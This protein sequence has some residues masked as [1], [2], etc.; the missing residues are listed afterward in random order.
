[1]EEIVAD[2]IIVGGGTAGCVISARLAEYGFETLLLS[3][4]SN[5]TLNSMMREKSLFNQLF[6]NPQFKHYLPASSSAN[7]NDRIL[8]IIVWN[9]LGGNSI[10][11]GGI[12][13]LMANDW[14]YFINAT[15][16]QS[17]HIKTMSKFYKMVENFTSTK[18]FSS[19]N[20]YGN[21]G[22]LKITQVYD[23]IFN[24]I[25]KK[26][27]KEL[28]ETFTDTSA[29]TL[30]YGFSFEASSFTNGIRSWSC[31][32]YLTSTLNKYPNLK[33]LT[34]ATAIKFNMNE[35]TKQ[36]KNVL[37]ISKDGL[38][39]GI[40]RKEYILSAG[41]IFSPHLLMLSGIGDRNILRENNILV[42]HELKQVGKNL[43]ENGMIIIKYQTQNFSI[44]QSI[45][46]ALINTQLR[47]NHS[48][49]DTFIILK[50]D[51]NTMHLY[52][53]IFNASPKSTVG[54]ISLYNSNPLIPPKIILD[55]LTD[56]KDIQTFINAINYVRKIMS[57]NTIKHYAN[58]TEILPGL[59][60][61]DLTAYIK[62]T[63]VP[64][65][66]FIGTCSIGQNAE[67]SVV[68]NLFKVH[69]ISNLRI[70]DASIFPR[71][72]STKTGPFL[73]VHALAEKAADILQKIYS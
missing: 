6:L 53:F 69:G 22:F 65:Y 2:F 67:N 57:T 1:M 71:K 40:A 52:V 56:S 18:P 8:D 66:H 41:T 16:D 50:Q 19:L 43:I 42:K 13:R 54:F 24:K 3:S 9:T 35:Q 11:G 61:T 55:Y 63:L 62:N 21:H 39:T 44:G 59:E 33:V 46:V 12:E 15:G 10:N 34:G 48:N 70:V 32:N 73:T 29:N 37:F 58:L 7:L 64:S 31:N 27:A 47:T 60:Q 38:F 49:P 51:N 25:W 72:F 20:N 4:G 23:P 26:V 5:D 28:N 30:D 17:F 14:N 68:D 36:I 45:P